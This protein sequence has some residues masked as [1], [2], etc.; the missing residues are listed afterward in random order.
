MSYDYSKL[1]G[2]IIEKFK[3]RRAFAEA[4]GISEKSLSAK[5][6]NKLPFKQREIKLASNLLKIEDNEVGA[7]FFKLC[8]QRN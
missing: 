8:A 7:Y 1:I 4:L 2:R 3:T 5:L 6:S